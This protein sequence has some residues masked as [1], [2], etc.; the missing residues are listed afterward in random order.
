MEDRSIISWKRTRVTSALGIEYPV[1]QGALGGL[2][3]QRLTAAVSN[4]GGLGSLGAHSLEPRIIQERIDEIRSLT[5]KP[6]AMNLWI[7]MEDD[8]AVSSGVGAFQ[9]ALSHISHHLDRVGATTPSYAPYKPLRFEDQVRVLIDAKVPAFSF[10]Y[11]LPPKEVLDECRRIGIVLMGTATTV[12]EAKV[13]ADAGVDMVVA[14]GFEAGGHRG[15]F[16][17]KAEDSLM[18]SMSLIPQVC[19][20][21]ELPVIAAGGI[22]D[23]RGVMAAFALGAEAVQVG[24]V[25][26]ACN[27][28]GASE[29]HRNALL[30]GKA[31][32]TGLT[33]GFTGRLARTIQNDLMTELNVAGAQILPY[34]L[35]RHLIRNLSIAA[36]KARDESLIPMWSGQSAAL[37]K[38]TDVNSVMDSLLRKPSTPV[39]EPIRGKQH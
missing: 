30:S 1:I 34:P 7:S 13:L 32:V 28:S 27:D 14:S 38:S 35:Q 23:A 9:K 12:D 21:V 20:A 17:R 2:S 15:S 18:G 11:G 36:E 39:A 24:T 25:F 8:D 22:A 4:Y 6:F 33:R 3:S 10:I 16:I 19:D 37:I 5:D 31:A 26:L 29:L